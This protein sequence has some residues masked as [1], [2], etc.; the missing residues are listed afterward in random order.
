MFSSD[1]EAYEGAQVTLSRVAIERCAGAGWL[2]VETGTVVT[3]RDLLVEGTIRPP[4]GDA[5]CLPGTGL[6]SIEGGAFSVTGFRI[7]DNVVCG[8]QLAAQGALDL[9]DGEVS[10][11]P[12]GAN[13]QSAEFD[14]ARLQSGVVYRDN[15]VTL[16]ASALPVPSTLGGI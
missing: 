11:N 12:I 9:V 1:L 15:D 3:M 2:S 14:V 4:C 16:D 13:V 7:S 5:V 10:R 8:V 6:A